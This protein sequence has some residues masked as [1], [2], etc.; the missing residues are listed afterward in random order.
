[1]FFDSLVIHDLPSCIR[2]RRL[3]FP[4]LCHLIIEIPFTATEKRTLFRAKTLSTPPVSNLINRN[5]VRIDHSRFS[6]HEVVH[7]LFINLEF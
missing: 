6:A 3:A 4:G 1:M 5:R 7:M 2:V